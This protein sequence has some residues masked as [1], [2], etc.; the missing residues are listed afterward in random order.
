MSHI[1]DNEFYKDSWGTP[2]MRQ[3]FDDR[4]RY[5]RWLDIEVVLAKV[6]A[7]MGGIPQ[8]AADEIARAAKIEEL[9]ADFIK[10]E[11]GRTGHS[12]LPLLKAV[13]K[14]CRD[15]LGE[16]IHYGPTTQDIEDTGAVLEIKEA[17]KILL[18]DLIRIEK[19][20]LFL[21][22]KY[23]DFPMAGR[24]HNQQGL[25]I[26]LG[27]KFANWAAE[28]R[29]GIERLKGI[30]ERV[31]V[32]MLHGGTGTM[33]GL[34]ERAWETA[35]R[36]ME[37]LGLGLPPTGWGSARDTVAEYQ[38]VLGILA[39]SLGRVS[40][41]IFQLARTEI[42]EFREPLGEHYVGSST[43]PHKRNPEVTEFIVAMC[44][45]VMSNVQLALQAMVSEHER[46][47]RAW[48]LDWHS[49][50]E[51]SIMLHKAL[52]ALTFIVEG[53]EIDEKRIGQNLDMLHGMLFSEAL[54]FYLGKKVGKQTAHH[55][56]RDAILG[57]QN[58]DKTFKELLM[59]S[60]V[61]HENLSLAE[62][63]SI[64]DYSKHVGESARQVQAVRAL[65]TKLSATDED[66]L[67]C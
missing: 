1:I 21:A 58:T 55:L 27:L 60:R 38:V 65:S 2:E 46:D 18:R 16:Y 36:V 4:V 34:G 26:T 35:E 43:M 7:E 31:F 52:S 57:T 48:R 56:I 45:I 5:Q 25:P 8:E 44:R 6:Q 9:D 11:L 19:A 29:R 54:M 62:L 47:T 40:N 39:G 30:R 66:F 28:I 22:E 49:I 61:I 24:T 33:A 50:P 53:L 23:K 20:I 3:V 15:N 41:E 17:S 42:N 59:D 51:S 32:G 12:L 63:D 67:N 14:R 10:A 64:M 37:R 13:Q